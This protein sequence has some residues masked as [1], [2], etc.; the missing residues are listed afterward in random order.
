MRLSQAEL[1]R[2]FLAALSG[3]VAYHSDEKIKPLEV[4]CYAPLPALLRVYIYNAT[5]PPGGRTLGEHKIQLIVPGQPRG[6]IGNFEYSEERIPLL[7]GYVAHSSVFVLWDAGC[8]RNFSYSRNV[9]VKA[10]TVH[11]AFCGEV[12]I[13]KRRLRTGMETVIACR[14]EKLT[15]AIELRMRLTLDRLIEVGS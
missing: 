5:D 1:H 6:E 4:D 2:L 11:A 10:E 13:Q 12:V 8:Y 15:K 14:G 9:Q 3:Q 7:V